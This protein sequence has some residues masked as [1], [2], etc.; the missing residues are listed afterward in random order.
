MAFLRTCMMWN[1]SIKIVIL[2]KFRLLETPCPPRQSRP[3]FHARFSRTN[4]G[5]ILQTPACL[6]YN[7]Q[8]SYA[9]EAVEIFGDSLNKFKEKIML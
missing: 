4:I 8:V 5:K 6:V 2:N 3:L 1:N 9:K 7:N